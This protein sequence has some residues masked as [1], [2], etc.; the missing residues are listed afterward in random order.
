VVRAALRAWRGAAAFASMIP[1]WGG[2]R[3]LRHAWLRRHFPAPAP[4]D[5]PGITE[6]SAIDAHGLPVEWAVLQ[7]NIEQYE[8]SGLLIKLA[9]VAL[10]I[11]ALVFAL[12]EVLT[13]ALIL[14][15]WVQE[16]VLR[17]FQSRLVKRILKIEEMLR[18]AG[19]AAFQLH[20]DWMASRRGAPGMLVE[21][22]AAALRPTVAFPYV[23]LLLIDLA[24]FASSAGNGAVTI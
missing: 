13:G 12:S 17:T 11:G 9:A 3:L 6:M 16:A 1:R 5:Q 7:N 24:L 21:Y 23:V 19:G 10:F 2:K 4:T 18:Q 8:R 20:S 22:A 14:I 15:L